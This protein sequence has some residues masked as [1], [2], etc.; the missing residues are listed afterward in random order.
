[1]KDVQ[2]CNRCVLDE[3][4]SLIEF[5]EKGECNFCKI[6]DENVKKYPT[7]E[8]GQKILN[9]ILEEIKSR[10]QNKDYDCIVGV[11]GGVDSTYTLYNAVKMGLR[12][13]AVQFDNGWH[14]EIAVSN[15][16]NACTKLG[17]DLHT[18][19]VDWEEFKDILRS[20]L[21]ASVPD[22]DIATDIGIK[23]TLYKVAADEGLKYIITGGNFRTEGQ[24]PRGW[25][26]MD[27]R[28]IRS[29]HKKFGKMRLK[30]FPNLTMTYYLYY[31]FVK[32]IKVIRILNYLDYEKEK[33]KNLLM[34]QLDW[35]D[36]GG[37]HYESIF[38]RFNNGFLCREKFN[39]DKRKIEF[40][41]MV[42][43]GQMDRGEA[44]IK[45]EKPPYSQEQMNEDI[46]YV[47]KKLG[48]SKKEF[49]QILSLPIKS[50]KDYPTY[51]PWIARV[52]PL[53]DFISRFISRL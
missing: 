13:L 25:T 21:L 40:A 32:R 50:Y 27:G 33:V 8:A 19:V 26:Y 34:E 42:R 43:S 14:S 46:E 9:G 23:A 37:K 22:A 38:T 39:I 16:K 51:Y 18:V 45:L 31:L 47:I 52:K 10:S 24:I 12:P 53:I 29:V 7:G 44:L 36:Y 30:R 48:F 17:V 3:G 41:A 11:S 28:Y 15:I 2:L 4:V 35:R 20:F 5:D 1:M 6:H 49:D